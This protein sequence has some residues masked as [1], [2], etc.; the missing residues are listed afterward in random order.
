[1]ASLFDARS[2]DPL[3]FFP[4][5]YFPETPGYPTSKAEADEAG[6]MKEQHGLMWMCEAHT[7][8][9]LRMCVSRMETCEEFLLLLTRRGGKYS[10]A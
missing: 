9:R 3:A 6:E 10:A 1:M 8:R 2:P 7:W 4:Q 5:D